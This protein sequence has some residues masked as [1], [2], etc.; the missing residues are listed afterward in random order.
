MKKAGEKG[1]ADLAIA[2]EDLADLVKNSKYLVNMENKILIFLEAPQLETWEKIRP[3]LSHDVYEI[4]YKFTDRTSRGQLKTLH[5]VIRGWPAAVYL[6]AG[7]GREDIIWPQIQSRFTTISPRMSAEKYRAAVEF[8]AMVK[9]LPSVVFESKIGA[10]EFER[11]ERIIRT[12]RHRLLDIKYK[13]RK[14]SKSFAP[15]T[16]WIPFHKE[17]GEEFPATVGRHMRD[18]KRFITVMQMSAATNVFAR[19]ILKIGDTENIVVVRADYERAIRLYF[20]EGGEE[21]FTGIPA[22]IIDFFKRVILSLWKGE[23]PGHEK[24]GGDTITHEKLGMGMTVAEMVKRYRG[25]YHK[26]RSSKTILNHYLPPL[27]NYGIITSEP[28]PEDKR[29]NL[30]TVLQEEIKPKNTLISSLFGKG[31]IFTRQMLEAR[32]NEL[33]QLFPQNPIIHNKDDTPLDLDQLWGEYY[34]FTDSGGNIKIPQEKPPIVENKKENLPKIEKGTSGKVL[35]PQKA[36]PTTQDLEK[37]ICSYPKKTLLPEAKL[38]EDLGVSL[39]RIR[40]VLGTLGLR[41]AM[42][43]RGGRMW[44]VM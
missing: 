3:I 23:E 5:V 29:R 36:E 8:S 39:D 14:A 10:R 41:G 24:I 20:E 2:K 9:G 16:F 12:I 33:N 42:I 40:V 26:G 34:Y 38:A 35:I 19:P 27:E 18:S 11:A 17:I 13:A 44:E 28:D 15:N 37:A 6:K 22:H 7:R 4:S 25:I 43:P 30:W 32:F 31:N 1:A 21:I